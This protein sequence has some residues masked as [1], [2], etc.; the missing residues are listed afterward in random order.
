MPTAISLTNFRRSCCAGRRRECGLELAIRTGDRCVNVPGTAGGVPGPGDVADHQASGSTPAS[1][2]GRLPAGGG[3]AS[4]AGSSSVG[5]SGCVAAPG[6]FIC[7][8]TTSSWAVFC[9]EGE[10][11]NTGIRPVTIG[12]I[13]CHFPEGMPASS[14]QLTV[15]GSVSCGSC[16]NCRAWGVEDRSTASSSVKTC[17]KAAALSPAHWYRFSGSRSSVLLITRSNASGTSGHTA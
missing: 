17:S 11:V 12:G 14:N 2:S 6:C 7:P 8:L 9:M 1:E 3:N 16:V 13:S 15:G 5:L 10:D 4:F